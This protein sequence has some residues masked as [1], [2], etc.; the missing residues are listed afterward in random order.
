MAFGK[1]KKASRMGVVEFRRRGCNA[2]PMS[3]VQNCG[4]AKRQIHKLTTRCPK[5]KS[6]SVVSG[7]QGGA[8]EV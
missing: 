8:K 2:S 1:N 7:S 4:G 3:S 6:C 5:K